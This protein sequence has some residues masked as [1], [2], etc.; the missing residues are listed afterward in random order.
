MGGA[1]KKTK[2]GN[3]QSFG[4]RLAQI[5]KAK[6][7]SQGEL[8]ARIG[9]SQR[10]MHHYENKAEYPPTGK[11]IE[12]TQALDINVDELLGVGNN[13]KHSYQNKPQACQKAEISFQSAIT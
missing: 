7:L 2:S 5:R 8:G 1:G 4:Q 10:I 3:N 13:D 12:L 9:I 11:I 6:G